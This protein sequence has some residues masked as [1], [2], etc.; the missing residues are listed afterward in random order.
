MSSETRSEELAHR[1]WTPA[2]FDA[3]CRSGVLDED[4]RLELLDGELVPM[5][6]PGERHTDITTRLTTTLA[7]K[8][9]REG[10]LV[11]SQSPLACG[12]SRPQ[13]DLYV[14]P[15]AQS[16]ADKYPRKALLVIEVAD[17]SLKQDRY[18]MGLYARAGIPEA[19]LVN[20]AEH[21]VEVH[22]DPNVKAGRYG[23]IRV[24]GTNATL[25]TSALPRLK[26]DVAALLRVRH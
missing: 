18:K 22:T 14:I 10:L 25:T 11:G 23:T 3:L 24:L 9:E 20:V 13:P 7:A 5:T 6:P 1:K 16:R 4:E 21:V 8:A 2:E 19:W 17:N 15:E 26:L 12:R